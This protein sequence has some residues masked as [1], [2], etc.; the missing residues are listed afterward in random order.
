MAGPSYHVIQLLVPDSEVDRI[1]GELYDLGCLGLEELGESR[2]TLKAYFDAHAPLEDLRKKIAK[3]AAEAEWLSGTTIG[4][5]DVSFRPS[6]FEPFHLVA[7][8]TVV[9]PAEIAGPQVPSPH[10]VVIMPGLAFGTGR[11]ET[12]RLVARALW[13]LKPRPASVLDV[14]TGSGILAIVAHKIGVP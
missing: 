2:V 8:L 11:H 12:T 5:T 4:L 3:H 7:H 14:G 13:H 6:S 9:P 1:Q 10:H